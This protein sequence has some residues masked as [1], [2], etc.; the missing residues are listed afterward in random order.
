MNEND[1]Y[2]TLQAVEVAIGVQAACL[3]MWVEIS[4]AAGT[5]L[6]RTPEDQYS[7][8]NEAVNDCL[9]VARQ[10]YQEAC[11]RLASAWEAVPTPTPEEVTAY[12]KEGF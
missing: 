10:H 11:S 1:V 3:D 5:A 9:A 7:R 8:V 12:L 2:T 4:V 6:S